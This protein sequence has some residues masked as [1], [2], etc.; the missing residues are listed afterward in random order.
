MKNLFLG[1]ILVVI[2]LAVPRPAGAEEEGNMAEANLK[3]LVPVLFVEKI[4]PCLPFWVDRLGFEK[5]TEV[6]EGDALGFVILAR[7]S[8]E[9]MLQTRASLKKDLPALAEE[10]SRSFLYIEVSDLQEFIKRL[11]GADVVVPV[12][13]TFYGAREIGV[14]DPAG[15]VITFAQFKADN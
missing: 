14:R 12:R 15:N 9:V 2:L 4:E 10:G 8:V 3:R 6:P 11:E 7:G 5:T 1:L 13:E